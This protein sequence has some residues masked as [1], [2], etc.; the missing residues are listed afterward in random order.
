VSEATAPAPAARATVLD[1][2]V[3]QLPWLAP[4]AASLIALCRFPSSSLW[5]QVCHDPGLVLFLARQPMGN[6]NDGCPLLAAAEQPTLL[7][8]FHQH[9]R[10]PPAGVIHWHEE[11]ARTILTASHACAQLAYELSRRSGLGEPESAWVC[12]LLAPL[13]WLLFCAVDPQGV[14]QALRAGHDVPSLSS[15]AR[16]LAR[17]W[18]LPDWLTAVAGFLALPEP[19]AVA[20][21]ADPIL[22][23]LTRIAVDL[24]REQGHD[25]RLLPAARARESALTLSLPPA[26]LRGAWVQD[27]CQD[28]AANP[29]TWQDPY[30]QPLLA[31]LVAVAGENRR[32]RAA[33]RLQRL[34]QEIDH[35]RLALE[36][37]VQSENERLHT[38]KLEAL[39]E[40]AAGA[41]HEINNPL[42]V[43]S[44]QAQYLLGH[45]ANWFTGEG[46]PH[47]RK[48]LQAIIGQ[49]RRMHGLLR[50]LMQFARP[51]A[52]NLTWIDLPTL[53]GEAAASL[54]EFAEQRQVRIAV[55]C[56]VDRLSIKVDAEQVRQVLGCLLRNAIE[57]APAEGWARLV[58]RRPLPG[59]EIE[60]AVEDSGAG[61]ETA[62]LAH[63]FD[64]FYSGRSS[65]RG[66]G[67]GLPIAWRLARLHGG[68]VTLE[69][70]TDLQPTRFLLHLPWTPS[71]PV[72]TRLA[73]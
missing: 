17:I 21:G 13:G 4:G 53:M 66:R 19:V 67:L 69:S 25:L 24:A 29:W 16:R 8:E 56:S 64:P 26:L 58:L 45:E 50:D 2:A 73:S 32:L 57:A 55:E 62:Q 54:H 51:P 33:P 22:F 5:P 15:L 68:N 63:L 31:D 36:M 30:Q 47:V 40:F 39:A 10:Q 1:V 49:T 18:N 20:L 46:H 7:N 34:E 38:A 14:Q 35:L 6:P 9:L 48:A 23:H 43:I 52:P 71:E 3:L 12:G 65:G 37:Q 70:S 60:V 42:A 59:K 72:I 41:G 61:P 11:P 28:A 27:A 44:G